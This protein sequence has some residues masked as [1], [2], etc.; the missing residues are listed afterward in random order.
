MTGP[1]GPA[2]NPAAD[3]SAAVAMLRQGRH[4]D[5]SRACRLILAR[6]PDHPQA[7]HMLGVAQMQQGDMTGALESIGTALRLQ[8]NDAAIHGNLGIVRR[9]TGQTK[10]ALHHF[11]EALRLRPGFIEALRHRALA[12]I[13]LR[14]PRQALAGFEQ[15]RATT[16]VTAGDE[17]GRGNALR[18]LGRLADAAAAFEAALAIEPG[19]MLAVN[20][21]GVVRQEQKRYPEAA[22]CFERVLAS[23]V[24]AD[25]AASYLLRSRRYAAD[26]SCDED[27]R[28][29][30]I[31]AVCSGQQYCPPFFFLSLS[32][33]PDEQRECATRY[34]A[35]HYPPVAPTPWRDEPYRHERIRVAYLSSDFREHPISQMIVGVLERHDRSRFEVVGLSTGPATGDPLRQR[36]SAAFDTFL[37]VHQ[38]T[39]AEVAAMIRAREIDILVDL[40]GLTAGCRLGIAARRP[41]PVQVSY[42]GFPGTMGVDYIDYLVADATVIPAGEDVHYAE[43][44][45]RLPDSYYCHDDRRAIADVVPSRAQL[46]LPEKGFVFCCFNN[47]YKITPDVFAQWM[48]LLAQVEGSVLWLF[49]DNPAASDNLRMEARRRGVQPERLVFAP[50]VA[51]A[52]HLARHRR[53][54]LCLDTLPYNAHTTACDALWAGV[55]VLTRPG[56]TFAARVAASLLRAIELPELIA[57]DEAHYEAIA[58]RLATDAGAM[59]ALREKLGNHRLTR[60]LFDTD[61]FRRHLEAA[62]TAMWQRSQRREPAMAMDIPPLS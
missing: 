19:N 22:A 32:R 29:A 21:L 53:A 44:V 33:R 8:P 17:I 16:A 26:W 46:G 2:T 9:A 60:P 15:L 10:L 39:D 41:A 42:L 18:A 51:T 47:S 12:L 43:R 11:D 30:L 48:R 36:V 59:A 37:D 57:T 20:S 49:D 13:D 4:Q 52:E 40:N 7:W 34:A 38:R 45:V 14:R 35:R 50:R 28:T 6:Q 56:T 5:A 54:D 62:Y 61:R 55:P 24:D 27:S 3:L 25:Y 58:L 23:G 1:L 31:G